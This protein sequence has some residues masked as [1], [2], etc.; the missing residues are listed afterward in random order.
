MWWLLALIIGSIVCGLYVM[1]PGVVFQ[2]YEAGKLFEFEESNGGG[3]A[4][5]PK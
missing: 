5:Q 4:L 2:S 3:G 1:R